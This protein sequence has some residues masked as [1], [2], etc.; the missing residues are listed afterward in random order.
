[1]EYSVRGTGCGLT[2]NVRYRPRTREFHVFNELRVTFTITNEES[3]TLPLKRIRNF[4]P[5]GFVPFHVTL[6]D[7]RE[8]YD[9]VSN[10][11]S[12]ETDLIAHDQRIINAHF[13]GVSTA[14]S[15][16]TPTLV[17]NQP[18]SGGEHYLKITRENLQMNQRVPV[19]IEY[20]DKLLYPG[21]E[22]T[23]NITLTNQSNKTIRCIFLPL[24]YPPKALNFFVGALPKQVLLMGQ[25]L[26]IRQTIPP[27][28]TLTISLPF[29][30]KRK[31]E[32]AKIGF[33]KKELTF[34]INA[35][36]IF[37]EYQKEGGMVGTSITSQKT[38]TILSSK[39]KYTLKKIVHSLK[40]LYAA[41]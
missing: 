28:G 16:H 35:G 26:L 13:L 39:L 33:T 36:T 4:A 27:T 19:K 25:K 12:L 8:K 21:K 9:A 14:E 40:A 11:L 20:D 7:W 23:T 34:T 41:I 3:Q 30:T 1:M 17:T 10:T 32:L 22:A 38:V 24:G 18:I 6:S 37:V 2:F 5:A 31:D 15:N 29:V